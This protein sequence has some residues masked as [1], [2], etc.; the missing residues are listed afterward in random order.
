MVQNPVV[1]VELALYLL[2]MLLI[3]SCFCRKKLT[4]AQGH[5]SLGAALAGATRRCDGA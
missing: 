5:A 2:G 3:G 1:L 4:R